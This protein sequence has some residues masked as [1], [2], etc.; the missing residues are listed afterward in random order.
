MDFY[1]IQRSSQTEE[2]MRYIKNQDC[3]HCGDKVIAHCAGTRV[4]FWC[5]G[6]GAN[7][8]TQPPTFQ[9]LKQR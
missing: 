8:D 6:C 4:V 1:K 7:D 2:T 9:I 5:E 3:R